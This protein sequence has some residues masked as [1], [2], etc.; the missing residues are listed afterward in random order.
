MELYQGDIFIKCVMSGS[1]DIRRCPAL[2]T[3]VCGRNNSYTETQEIPVSP[4]QYFEGSMESNV[5][6]FFIHL[7]RAFNTDVFIAPLLLLLI[8]KYVSRG[9]KPKKLDAA[10]IAPVCL[11]V[12]RDGT[13]ETQFQVRTDLCPVKRE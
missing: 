12:I 5:T 3:G 2:L 4:S 11:S 7:A 9:T 8:E 13:K 6:R 1:N 10:G